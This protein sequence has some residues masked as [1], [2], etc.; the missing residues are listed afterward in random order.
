ML[1]KLKFVYSLHIIYTKNMPAAQA[2]EAPVITSKSGGDNKFTKIAL[3]A[4]AVVFLIILSEAAYLIFAKR[5]DS[6][7]NVDKTTVQE[8]NERSTTTSQPQPTAPPTQE[9]QKKDF[10]VDTNK[11]R[12]FADMLDSLV[13]SGKIENL[14]IA[15]I[16]YESE[17]EIGGIN[18]AYYLVLDK[19]NGTEITYSLTDEEVISAQIL[20]SSNS[21]ESNIP[22]TDIKPGDIVTI[23]IVTNL[24][25]ESPHGN[26]VLEVTR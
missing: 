18:Y 26:V 12:V 14:D 4:L 10:V 2:Q 21:E 11:A 19:Q 7:F 20:L 16:N 1:F 9:K 22:I 15:T 17:K 6:I 8:E 5:G 25:D 23:K 13:A 24:L 3:I